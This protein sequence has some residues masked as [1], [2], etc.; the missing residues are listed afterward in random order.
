[1]KQQEIK[2]VLFDVI[3]A[4]LINLQKDFKTLVNDS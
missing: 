1:M 4:V 2:K 3:L